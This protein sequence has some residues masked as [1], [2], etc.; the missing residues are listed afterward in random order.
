MPTSTSIVFLARLN[1]NSTCTA[2]EQNQNA[3][4]A[5]ARGI[6]NMAPDP[7][8]NYIW[9]LQGTPRDES[10]NGVI[11]GGAVRMIPHVAVSGVS[12]TRLYARL[13]EAPGT[14]I[15]DSQ[16]DEQE[17]GIMVMDLA[18]TIV[19]ITVAVLV[20]MYAYRVG[21]SI[22]INEEVFFLA[23]SIPDPEQTAQLRARVSAILIS[24]IPVVKYNKD[25]MEKGQDDTE[26]S[27][28]IDCAVCLDTLDE[29]DE[30]RKLS[31]NHL[32]HK[33]CIDPWLLDHHNCPLCKDDI[34][35]P[36]HLTERRESVGSNDFMMDMTEMATGGSDGVVNGMVEVNLNLDEYVVVNGTNVRDGNP[37]SYEWEWSS[38]GAGS[39]VSHVDVEEARSATSR[40]GVSLEAYGSECDV[41]M[42]TSS[43][44]A[45]PPGSVHRWGSEHGGSSQSLISGNGSSNS[46]VDGVAY[47]PESGYRRHNAV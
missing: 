24:D 2:V 30:V 41:D 16:K 22:C 31:C 7:S 40:D 26:S 45:G 39:E 32:F 3:R 44:A 27:E 14:V 23:E 47:S 1:A 8:T 15:I 34:C 6:I 13:I 33:E 10:K 20:L 17:E 18:I 29:G 46:L 12:G 4:A 42:P 43:V 35:A 37:N 11:D 38:T 36:R 9:I 28:G 19:C 25:E 5:G 21:R